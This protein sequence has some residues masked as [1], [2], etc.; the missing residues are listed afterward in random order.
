VSPDHHQPN[1]LLAESRDELETFFEQDDPGPRRLGSWGFSPCW[2]RRA[3]GWKLNACTALCEECFI[4][5]VELSPEVRAETRA[6]WDEA[7]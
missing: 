6:W 1:P 3:R 5:G 4:R 7:K 2:K